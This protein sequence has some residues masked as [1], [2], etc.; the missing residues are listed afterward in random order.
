MGILA[1]IRE[2]S[3]AMV[4]L[5]FVFVLH[6]VCAHRVDKQQGLH[7]QSAHQ[8]LDDLEAR[9]RQVKS[10]ERDLETKTEE[11]SKQQIGQAILSGLLGLGIGGVAAESSMATSGAVPDVQTAFA[12]MLAGAAGGMVAGLSLDTSSAKYQ[13]FTSAD[14]IKM[15]IR[16][17]GTG[18]MSGVAGGAVLQVGS[19][20]SDEGGSS[21]S[22]GSASSSSD[23]SQGNPAGRDVNE[24][25]DSL[26]FFGKLP[27]FHSAVAGAA[28][29]A[30]A[31]Y[32]TPEIAEFSG[33]VGGAVTKVAGA[34]M[35]KATKV[36]EGKKTV[37]VCVGDYDVHEGQTDK[38]VFDC[39]E[40]MITNIQPD[41]TS[42]KDD[43]EVAE[44]LEFI[45]TLQCE[46]ASKCSLPVCTNEYCPVPGC[47]YNSEEVIGAKYLTYKCVKDVSVNVCIDDDDA[48]A[49]A[50]K[51]TKSG[52]VKAPIIEKATFYGLPS[53]VLTDAQA[54]LNRC[55][56]G[57]Q[58]EI[59]VCKPN[60]QC[61]VPGCQNVDGTLETRNFLFACENQETVKGIP[62]VD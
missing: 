39:G 12:H 46:T 34:L 29:A 26:A 22:S 10:G 54:V 42:Y 23:S 35:H 44:V 45:A 3:S 25:H 33:A 61:S 19:G 8:D 53:Q 62:E 40:R 30:A 16:S 38:V 50:F 24:A 36:L 43:T 7:G 17:A 55:A 20:S 51:C 11:D 13:E 52:K 60:A 28:G 59:D 6:A 49:V 15:G 31:G 56:G 21:A 9:I 14:R 18:I 48:K 37:N 57:S 47:K 41:A 5:V 58:C 2:P 4:G 1:I 27:I 32:F